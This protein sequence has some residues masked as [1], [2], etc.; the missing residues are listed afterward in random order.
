MPQGCVHQQAI[1]R[2]FKRLRFLF[3]SH[4]KTRWSLVYYDC[5]SDKKRTTPNAVSFKDFIYGQLKATKPLRSGWSQVA[6]KDVEADHHNQHRRRHT[7]PEGS[8]QY[9]P[10]YQRL[11]GRQADDDAQSI[12]YVENYR[13]YREK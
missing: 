7:E 8:D 5:V 2:R 10:D 9:L 13:A 12:D 6:A 3:I 11:A 4:R 1:T